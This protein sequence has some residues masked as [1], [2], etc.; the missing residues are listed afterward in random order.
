MWFVVTHYFFEFGDSSLFFGRHRFHL[1]VRFCTR[2]RANQNLVS[3]FSV[4]Y[5]TTPLCFATNNRY[6]FFTL[7]RVLKLTPSSKIRGVSWSSHGFKFVETGVSQ[8]ILKLKMTHPWRCLFLYMCRSIRSIMR[9]CMISIACQIYSS[10]K[11]ALSFPY[12]GVV[13]I[14][15]D[16]KQ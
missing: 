5:C 7:I 13:T 10:K 14:N 4:E 11:W 6:K 2:G 3:S 12:N 9:K 16:A 1:N 15:N 8:S